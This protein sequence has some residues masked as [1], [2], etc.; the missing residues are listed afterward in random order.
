MGI[1]FIMN[2]IVLT[3]GGTGGHVTPNLALIDG[4]KLRFDEIHYIGRE[5]GIERDLIEKR[6]DVIYH[7]CPC[8]KLVRG[9]ILSNLAL[10]VKLVKSINCAKKILRQINPQVIFSKGGFVALPVVLGAGKIPVVLHES[11]STMGLSN[12]IASGFADKILSAFELPN[13]KSI[14]VGAPLRKEIYGA[15]P[16]RA[17][18]I[19]GFT[20]DKPVLLITGG[21]SGARVIN[22][23]VEQ[24]RDELI[25]NFNIVHIAGKGNG[26]KKMRGYYRCE[27]VEN[28]PDFLAL[29]SLA[30]TRGGA[31]TLFELVALNKPFI[32]VPLPKGV[33]RGDQIEN[34]EYFKNLG[35]CSVLSQDDLSPASLVSTITDCLKNKTSL[36]SAQNKLNEVDGREKIIKILCDYAK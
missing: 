18:H 30:V 25:K 33:S 15:Y 11:D 14:V 10:P 19:C 5:C 13:K 29:C 20:D 31:N 8:V 22:N 36:I 4:L 16:V 7:A 17:H 24:A 6:S 3:G 23:A 32:V 28:M 26:C 27:F 9:K 2:K 35:C 21:S 12:K 1:Y 34:A